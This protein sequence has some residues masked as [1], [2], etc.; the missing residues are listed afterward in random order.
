MKLEEYKL[1][2][3][4]LLLAFTLYPFTR[5]AFVILN[6]EIYKSLSI[7]ELL[8]PFLYGF[9]FDF[10][11]VLIVNSVFIIL[12]LIP[13]RHKIFNFLLKLVFILSNGIAIGIN[14]VD[15]EF[16]KFNGKKLTADIF[17]IGGDMSDQIIQISFYYW[18][19]VLVILLSFVFY[20]KFYPV[21]SKY[22]NA[23][24]FP[25]T[26]TPFIG[27]S[28]IIMTFLGIRGGLQMRSISPK[29]AYI[30]PKYVQGHIAIN[31]TYTLVRSL[32]A[33]K[34]REV[35][36]FKTYDEA[37]NLIKGLRIGDTDFKGLKNSNV[38]I[39]ILESFSQEYIDDGFTPFFS[40]LSKKGLYFNRNLANGRRSIEALPSILVGMPSLIDKPLYQ[41][42]YQTN[43]FYGLAYYLNQEGYNS[44]FFH[45]GKRGTMDFDAYTRSIGIP[46][47]FGK[48]DYPFSEHFDG[49]WGIYDDKFMSWFGEELG[50]KKE[51]FFSTF[52]SLSSHQPYSIPKEFKNK[53]PKGNLEIHESIGYVDY[54]LQEFFRKYNNKD[55]FKNTL[56]VITAD[57]T[58][59]TKGLRYNNT[60]GKYRVPLL[61]YHPKLD[62]SDLDSKKV[63]QHA[64]IIHSILDFLDIEPKQKL[65]FG[66]SVFSKN[67]ETINLSYING[68]YSLFYKNIL[69]RM[70]D[71]K[72]VNKRYSKDLHSETILTG[73]KQSEE[74][75]ALIQYTINGLIKNQLYQ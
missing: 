14:I 70:I 38:I 29:Q 58:Q 30:F 47:Y 49:A 68:S 13:I 75:K 28:L 57:H 62:L 21:I 71:G 33:E 56:F 25:I 8:I 44:S 2:F 3:K 65:L 69:T 32:E 1:L 67:Y 6:Y 37:V 43:S 27:L 42:Q 55:W 11:T 4:R 45:G 53:F 17:G 41:S 22:S 64:D 52:F 46:N 7:E 18:P 54:S 5:I 10:S 12:S 23:K 35:N 9:R 15:I 16:F 60:L 26:W 73:Q 61:F 34:I 19:Y 72:T 39:L 66:E 24:I 50:K 40:E 63:T 36:Y 51:P 59:K 31:S 20:L 48:E 74:L